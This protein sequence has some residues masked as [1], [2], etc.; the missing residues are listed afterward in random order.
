MKNSLEVRCPLFDH[1]FVELAN[2]CHRILNTAVYS[3]NIF[4]KTNEGKL[5]KNTFIEKKKGF[6]MPFARWLKLT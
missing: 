2:S 5:P 4:L 6:G 1:D 3:E